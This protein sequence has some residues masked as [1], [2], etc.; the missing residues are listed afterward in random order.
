MCAT[1]SSTFLEICHY[2]KKE[3]VD[4]PLLHLLT[5]ECL[6]DHQHKGWHGGWEVEK[7]GA[8][9]ARGHLAPES[10]SEC[11]GLGVVRGGKAEQKEQAEVVEARTLTLFAGESHAA[12]LSTVVRSPMHHRHVASQEGLKKRLERNP[13]GELSNDCQNYLNDELQATL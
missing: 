7:V 9:L 5:L 12:F 6:S 10:P 13:T 4:H 8:G 3:E 2:L 1:L 11:A